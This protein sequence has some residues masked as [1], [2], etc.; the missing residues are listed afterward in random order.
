M[1]V[2]PV[3]HLVE[4]RQGQIGVDRARPVE[5]RRVDQRHRPAVA[6]MLAFEHEGA[7]PVLA[8]HRRIDRHRLD[9]RAR[10]EEVCRVEAGGHAALHVD[11][12]EIEIVAGHGL[13]GD[14]A[15]AEIVAHVLVAR[16]R[17][18]VLGLQI[19]P[20][21][22]GDAGIAAERP[23]LAN[24]E[25]EQLLPAGYGRRRRRHQR[26]ALG[27]EREGVLEIDRL[28]GIARDG[29]DGRRRRCLLDALRDE[30]EVL[31]LVGERRRRGQGEEQRREG[32]RRAHQ[33]ILS[34]GR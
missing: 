19:E 25:E 4:A 10:L 3:Q 15:L 16:H 22:I 7:E 8:Q 21:A 33:S 9:H 1:R 27:I 12:A 13:P 5:L 34:R 20:A 29:L 30:V 11:P 26:A 24:V 18:L 17:R 14:E 31:V 32:G 6:D 23:L 28:A 2:G